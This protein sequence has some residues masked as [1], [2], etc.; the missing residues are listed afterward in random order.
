MNKLMIVISSLSFVLLTGVP[1]FAQDSLNVR[2]LG[3]YD[4]PGEAFGVAVSGNY[5][6]VADGGEGTETDWDTGLR[7]VNISNPAAPSETGFYD[8]PGSSFSVAVLG[9]HAY[10]ADG[11]QGLRVVNITNP[12]SPV[13]AGWCYTPG[14][15][16]GVAVAG[17]YAY[18][19]SGSGGLQV[20]N[21][22]NSSAPFEAGYYYSP[23]WAGG[24]AVSGNYAYVAD[25][26]RGLRVVNITNPS[27]PFEVGFYD[28]PG[29]ASG[30]AV[31]GN[32]AYVADGGAGL[33][34][35]N[36]TNP[37]A[38][39]EV[40]FYGT[41]WGTS[42]VAVSGNYAYVADGG[43]GLRVVNITNPAAPY[44]VGF[45]IGISAQSVAVQGNIA[46]VGVPGYGFGIYDCS[47]A[48]ADTFGCNR[49]VILM[50][51]NP[52]FPGSQ[53]VSACAHVV[54]GLRTM[55]VVPVNRVLNT[56]IVTVTVGCASDPACAP[57]EGWTLA[58]PWQYDAHTRSFFTTITGRGACC[59]VTLNLD[60]ILPVELLSFSAVPGD[61]QV[62]LRWQTASE[63]GSD[64][65]EIE[66]DGTLVHRAPAAGDA[67]GHSYSWT[68]RDVTNGQSYHYALWSVEINGE[69][70][71]LRET[72]ATPMQG[73]ATVTEYALHGNYPNPFNPVTEIAFDLPEAGT[74]S[75][76]VF[77]V[78]GR[79]VA[80]LVNEEKA[81][82]RHTISFDA[83]DLPSGM[84]I[85][86]MRANEFT[87]SH[88]MMLIR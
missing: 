79:E 42:D 82:G 74:V 77:D 37:A 31:S 62:L 41:P 22:A 71:L 24:V 30:V 7:V 10:L 53:N 20:V 55:I 13:E 57:A 64:R 26:N 78:M 34:V 1:S 23:G 66:R 11:T 16:Y 45:Y 50:P 56:P 85:C 2:Q 5:A 8:S 18:V 48:M 27:S 25:G 35:V 73:I 44:E 68:D 29:N 28:T 17:S 21:I 4:T 81:A 65:F 40:G 75:L 3:F 61:A 84:Y 6:Y 58:L 63:T 14:Y 60:Y 86:R 47:A 69:R 38:P 51:D 54:S 46:Y 67:A 39:F 33:R 36:I 52:D 80:V 49:T 87:A 76:K 19:A 32:Y 9:N 12:S 83:R 15:A 70:S 72:D 43:G 88:K 59:C